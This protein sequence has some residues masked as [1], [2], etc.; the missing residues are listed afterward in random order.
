MASGQC[1]RSGALLAWSEQDDERGA[2]RFEAR[3]GFSM[4]HSSS[5]SLPTN[6]KSYH[7]HR[8]WQ[9]ASERLLGPLGSWGFLGAFGAS[10]GPLGVLLG[11]SWRPLGGLWGPLGGA[12][13]ASL[14]LLGPSSGGGLEGS[15]RHHPVG[16]I[17]GHLGGLSG[18]S[19][20]PPGL[21]WGPLG[22]SWLL[23]GPLGLSWGDL[24]GLLDRL[25]RFFDRKNGNVKMR[26]KPTEF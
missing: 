20:G 3:R 1:R 17:L 18:S 14:G 23:L 9:H 13:G 12:S 22:P 11:A 10:W 5:L 7:A 8:A 15:V 19:W 24:G 26:Q 25:R 4:V 6:T 2:N 21:S 16:A